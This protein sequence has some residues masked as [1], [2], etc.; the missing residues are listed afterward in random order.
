MEDLL[1]QHCNAI[2]NQNTIDRY[3]LPLPKKDDLRIAMNGITL[4]SI[5]A[6]IYSALLHNGKLRK[7]LGRTKMAFGKI[8]PR[9][10]KF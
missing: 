3:I 5:V 4:T 2:Y 1:L 8:Y 9:H 7:Y 10:H 6:K